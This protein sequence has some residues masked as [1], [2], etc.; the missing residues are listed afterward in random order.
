MHTSPLLTL[1]RELRDLILT[2]VL[3]KRIKLIHARPDAPD[4]YNTN[5]ILLANQQ[6]R[7]EAIEAFYRSLPST[8]IIFSRESRVPFLGAPSYARLRQHIHHLVLQTS[9]IKREDVRYFTLRRISDHRTKDLLAHVITCMP[10]L[11][12]VDVE[13]RWLPAEAGSVLLP[14]TRGAMMFEIRV[15]TIGGYEVQGWEVDFGVVDESRWRRKWWGWVGLK[16]MEV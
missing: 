6:L 9:Y 10:K 15:V 3:P 11:R 4:F 8:T 1:P 2:Y 13:V 12:Q 5:G 7:I 14:G 16:K